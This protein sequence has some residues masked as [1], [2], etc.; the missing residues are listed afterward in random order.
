MFSFWNSGESLEIVSGGC[1]PTAM[2]TG[3]CTQKK[4]R[5]SASLREI[6]STY[7]LIIR[8]GHGRD[9]HAAAAFIELHLTVLEREERP[10]TTGADILPSDE[11]RA[12]LADDDAASGDHFTAEGLH[13]EPLRITVAA[14]TAGALS[15]FMC[16]SFLKF[17]FLN[18]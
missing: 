18:F 6:V 3:F 5:R 13:A 8:G 9:V 1:L 14:V 10:I 7:E 15:F 4:R 16:H 17:D 11:F 2:R 12:A